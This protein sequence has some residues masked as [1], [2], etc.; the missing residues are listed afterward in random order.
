MRYSFQKQLT[1]RQ[2]NK[3]PPP[4]LGEIKGILLGA[5]RWLQGQHDV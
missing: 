1:R 2:K 4:Q 5:Q 3:T